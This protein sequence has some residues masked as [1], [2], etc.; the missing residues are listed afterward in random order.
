MVFRGI[1]AIIYVL[2][3]I[4]DSLFNQIILVNSWFIVPITIAPVLHVSSSELLGC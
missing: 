3:F 1:L 2:Y 4:L